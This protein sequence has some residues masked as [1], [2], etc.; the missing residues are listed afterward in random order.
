M[1]EHWIDGTDGSNSNDGLS[2]G[3]P[4]KD[5]VPG[6]SMD[7]DTCVINLK[8]GTT[9]SL[10]TGAF[11]PTARCIIRPYGDGS[12]RAKL[13]QDST[14]VLQHTGESGSFE[15]DPGLHLVGTT[16]TF[17]NSLTAALYV[18]DVW[19]EG[20]QNSV[21]VG[22]N[23]GRVSHCR[24]WDMTNNGILGGQTSSGA[25][26]GLEALHNHIDATGAASDPISF[27]DGTGSGYG[28]VIGWNI[29]IGGGDNG[30]GVEE[31]YFG[32]LVIGNEIYAP[33][34]S[35]IALSGS[36]CKLIGNYIHG[37][38]HAGINSGSDGGGH[39]MTGNVMYDCG[40]VADSMGLL[41]AGSV[42]FYFYNNTLVAGPNSTAA[43]LIQLGAGTSGYVKN[44][45]LA[46]K[47]GTNFRYVQVVD[48][49]VT[50]FQFSN[51]LY[52]GYTGTNAFTINNGS[53]RSWAQWQALTAL[54]GGTQDDDSMEGVD[55]G[56]DSHCRITNA[57]PAYQAGTYIAKV[58]DQCGRKLRRTPDIGAYQYSARRSAVGTNRSA[59]LRAYVG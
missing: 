55:P 40:R 30:I 39:F 46:T 58:K 12:A 36:G 31:Q 16:G 45:I 52:Y 3:A 13:V 42:P 33:T 10:T 34:E 4:K 11:R 24:L 18:N 23:G 29:C 50:G 38:G 19:I 28:G 22:T 57:S 2:A 47:D 44:N 7:D 41:V 6:L 35:G 15:F 37:C 27:H 49:D 25:A 53:P 43:R 21:R 48:A 54:D 8:R 17:A 14:N 9:I 20:F 26:N 32:I 56:L 5:F 1:A 59:A 51:N